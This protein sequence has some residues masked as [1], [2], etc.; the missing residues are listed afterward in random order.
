MQYKLC[1]RTIHI[2]HFFVYTLY[3]MFIYN[4]TTMLYFYTLSITASIF[5]L[6]D[7][8]CLAILRPEFEL[9]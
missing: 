6:V 5:N 4:K 8:P 3:G 9:N 7:G 1:D 2:K